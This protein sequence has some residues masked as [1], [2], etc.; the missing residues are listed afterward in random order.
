MK[1]HQAVS[2]SAKKAWAKQCAMQL[3]FISES[4]SKQKDQLGFELSDISNIIQIVEKK[5]VSPE[6][7]DLVVDLLCG[8][9]QGTVKDIEEDK[10]VIFLTDTIIILFGYKGV[11]AKSIDDLGSMAFESTEDVK[12]KDRIIPRFPGVPDQN[13]LTDNEYEQV[14]IDFYNRLTLQKRLDCFKEFFRYEP[15]EYEVIFRIEGLDLHF[16][17]FNIGK[18]IRV[19]DPRKE[20][21]I[22]EYVWEGRKHHIEIKERKGNCISVRMQGQDS[23]SLAFHAR[24]TAE[25]AL[26]LALLSR[27][28]K[29]DKAIKLSGDY[30]ICDSSGKE[31]AFQ[32]VLERKEQIFPSRKE[33]IESYREYYD[34]WLWNSDAPESIRRW[35]IAIDWYRHAVE[36][37]QNSQELLNAWFAIEQLFKGIDN[38]SIRVPSYLKKTP[39]GVERQQAWI[40]NKNVRII[41]FILAMVQLKAELR[42]IAT[43]VSSYFFSRI[44]FFSDGYK[45]SDRLLKQYYDESTGIWNPKKFVEIIDDI[46]VELKAN[47]D[48]PAANDVEKVQKLFYDKQ[49]CQ[50]FIKK[51]FWQIKD[52]IYNI[53]RIRNM[54]V[55]AGETSSRLLRY[56][57]NRS[58]EYDYSL[59]ETLKLKIIDSTKQE[60]IREIQDYL[61][62][63]VLESNVA[64]EELEFDNMK[65]LREWVFST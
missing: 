51:E 38:F 5:L 4:L 54:L 27:R 23:G 60:S 41:Q 46:I 11:L 47:N 43:T 30:G 45:L 55:H 28:E 17:G 1:Q 3:S 29:R 44:S 39:S 20:Q 31:V 36:S 16:D 26:A 57:A 7:F 24:R 22:K 19:Y 49:Y 12:Y 40:P 48:K 50:K 64:L 6:S 13:K 65:V 59:L 42:Q 9:F 34:E 25:R 32:T 18:K 10:E 35:L 58:R 21:R 33:V 53:Y 8:K 14:L 15:K 63:M 2:W 37:D 52:D 62:Q 61:G 56:Y